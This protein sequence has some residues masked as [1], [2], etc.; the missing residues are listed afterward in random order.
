M[1]IHYFHKYYRLGSKFMMITL[2]LYFLF[3]VT[4]TPYVFSLAEEINIELEIS[5]SLEDIQELMEEFLKTHVTYY[6]YPVRPVSKYEEMNEHF[7]NSYKPDIPFP[8]PKSI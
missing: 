4:I 6:Q 8:P 7:I 3:F 5:E 1:R 2:V